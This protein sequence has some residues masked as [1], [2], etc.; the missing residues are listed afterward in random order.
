[1]KFQSDALLSVKKLAIHKI[2]VT[3]HRT[4]N[5]RLGVVWRENLIDVSEDEI[6]EGFKEQMNVIAVL[7]IKICRKDKEIATKR[8][9]LTFNSNKVSSYS[10]FCFLD[11]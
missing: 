11:R 3:A 2:H 10:C 7:R 1:M 8:L 6:L 5:A 4:L 9:V